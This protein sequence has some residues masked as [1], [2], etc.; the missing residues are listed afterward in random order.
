M[1]L[2]F[3]IFSEE[4]PARMQAAAKKTFAELAKK[5]FKT[6]DIAFK[7][8][9][10][11]ISPRRLVLVIQG[12]DFSKTL[13]E[14]FIY[15]KGPSS[16][17]SE[18]EL[19]QF[20]TSLQ[21]Q[22]FEIIT[23]EI[24]GE[25]YF[26]AKLIKPQ[27]SPQKLVKH[28][29]ERIIH[30][31]PWPKSMRWDTSAVKWVRPIRN[32][33]CILNEKILPVKYGNLIA[34]NISSGH[35]FLSP[36]KFS[37]TS[38]KDYFSNLK[39]GK[40]ILDSEERKLKI[41]N[42][43]TN[44]LPQSLK[45]IEDEP[46]LEEVAGLVEYPFVLIG[47]LDKKFLNLPKEIIISS[48][49]THQKY[50]T[51]KDSRGKLAPYFIVVSNMEIKNNA[52][53]ILKGN[54]KVLRA[55][56]D[57]AQF[58]FKEDTKNTFDSKVVA[59]KKIIFHEKLGTVFEKV[60]QT[61]KLIEKISKLLPI[62]FNLNFAK[63]AAQLSK[64]DL[65]TN[66][67]KEFPE[68]QG[69]I[70]KYYA[71][72]DGENKIVTGAIAEHYL[73]KGKEEKFPSSIEGGIVAIA[74]KIITLV[75]LFSIGEIPT[76]SKDPYSLRRQAVGIIKLICH[77]KI[78]LN[79]KELIECAL[80]LLKKN[81]S[82]TSKT[83]T[84]FLFNR[85]KFFLKSKFK[86]DLIEAV[87]AVSIGNFYSDFNKLNYLNKFINSKEGQ[88]TFLSIKRVLNILEPASKNF[89]KLN[90]KLFN[91]YEK[92]LY[93]TLIKIQSKIQPIIAQQDHI[94]AL[95]IFTEL[96]K[97]INGFFD[98][99]LVMDDDPSLRANRLALLQKVSQIFISFA[100]FSYIEL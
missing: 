4:I 49:R 64:A 100:N 54:Q 6:A 75:G 30:E 48:L 61:E 60:S 67:V 96:A 91:K 31:F 83:I 36:K 24:Q 34:N 40:V 68:L 7:S 22:K 78:D 93:S 32:L 3:E 29:L 17:A 97:A 59:L 18:K 5:E 15:K 37:V 33:L 53:E 55:R 87:L 46:L 16:S 25:K 26:F 56:L 27:E 73:P 50:F 9:N 10:S 52:A 19:E 2:V 82:E 8:L 72:L 99:V 44:K 43:I 86:P 21:S 71:A 28:I 74:D 70:G 58:F 94:A 89:S 20:K 65:T 23:K 13:V 84:E 85:F 41:K 38:A 47:K 42:E 11:F 95:K 88:K 76:S 45:M 90:E 66:L 79:I 14:K 1:E 62:K 12:L 63:R 77:F 51:V 81:K 98:K 80:A 39:K 92:N 35:R 57:D 69:I